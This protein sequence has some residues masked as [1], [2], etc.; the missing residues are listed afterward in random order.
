MMHE[1]RE[2]KEDDLAGVFE[3][4]DRDKKQQSENITGPKS[5]WITAMMTNEIKSEKRSAKTKQRKKREQMRESGDEF[6]MVQF[7]GKW[8]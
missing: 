3:S 2:K 7:R 5:E 4:G 8:G 6:A 1:A